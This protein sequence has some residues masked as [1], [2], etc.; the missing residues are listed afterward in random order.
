MSRKPIFWISLTL[1][2]LVGIAFTLR[3]FSEAFPIVTLN[4]KM[5]RATA[6]GSARNLAAR[7]QW[8]PDGFSQAASFELDGTVQNYVE[9]EVGRSKAFRELLREGLYAPYTWRVRHFKEGEAHEALV[10]FTPEGTPYG[11]LEKLR[12][13][14]P[15]SSL[16]PE[17]ARPIAE[18]AAA[19]DW[20]IRLAEYVLIESSQERRPGG[21]TD[22]AFVYERPDRKIGEGL[23]RLRL[24]VGGDK[25]TELTHFIK[26]PEAF[27][28]RYEEMRSAN[29]T[30]AAFAS[31]AM[32]LLYIVGGCAVGLFF[33][34]RQ[35][36]VLWR[37]PLFWG[38]FIAF[39]NLLSDISE[40]PLSW[41]QYDTALSAR[42]FLT[43]QLLAA[44]GGFFLWT[45]LLTLT[46]MAAE[47]L[48]RKAFPHLIRFWKLWSPDTASSPSVLG[49]TL[50][51]YL[52]VGLDFAFVVATYFLTTR[53]FGWWTPSDVLFQPN[54]LATYFPWLSPI[55]QSLQAG[56][57]E[58]CLFRA[59][60]LA[61]AALLGDR[62]GSRKGF[63]AVGFVLQ[64]LI[65][66]A[67]HANYPSQPAYA[68][69]VEL[70]IPSFVFGG[71]YL[72]FGL[73]PAIISHFTFD[74][75]W[76]SIPLF[77][78]TARGVWISQVMVVLLTLTPLWVVLRVRLRT[79]KWLAL[80]DKHYNR[81]WQPEPVAVEIPEKEEVPATSMPVLSAR[82]LLLATAAGLALWML[83]TR[84][85]QDAAPLTIG[86]PE[87]IRIA[88]ETLER[89]GVKLTREWEVLPSVQ[90]GVDQQDRF[91]WQVG[92]EATYRRL[93]G[94]YLNPPGWNVRFARFT[95]D[96][97]ERT[98]E[99]NV[100]I[101]RDGDVIQ[102][103]HQ[104]PESLPGA[105]LAEAEA[106]RVAHAALRTRF[107]LD[108]AQLQE[109]S[110]V[111][112]KLPKRT[113]WVF[114]FSDPRNY[115]LKVGQGRA[116]ITVAGD[117]VA[118]AHQF[119]FV[120][121]EWQRKERSHRNIADLIRIACWS[122]LGLGL[123]AAGVFAIVQWSRRD[124]ST[125]VFVQVVLLVFVFEILNGWNQWPSVQ[126]NFSTS[127]PLS[128]Q[129][130]ITIAG[131]LVGA[132]LQALLFAL[133]MG[134]LARMIPKPANGS[135][136]HSWI[137]AASVAVVL[138]GVM[139]G[140]ASWFG[141]DLS[142]EFADYKPATAYLPW[143]SGILSGTQTWVIATA[144]MLL[145]FGML[146][147]ISHAGNRRRGVTAVL[148][149][150]LGLVL[151]GTE[152]V[153]TVG[154]WFLSGSVFGLLLWLAYRYILRSDLAVVPIAVGITLILNSVVEAA[155]A[156]FPLA[157]VCSLFEVFALV[158]LAYWGRNRLFGQAERS[159]DN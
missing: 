126:A 99:Y 104:L 23:Y 103:S 102:V 137:R 25:L 42:E 12:E 82:W 72:T 13:E 47:S 108:A 116:A 158:V 107:Q 5:D 41:M 16:A 84:F 21:R 55:A 33:L 68:R 89:Q 109:V 79:G 101:V 159:V 43:R 24:V 90:G 138:A 98:E 51:G 114:T 48:T 124:F 3:Y 97:V 65:F 96:V 122:F 30:I 128:H 77:V 38:L 129:L 70:I 64:A 85:E 83:S 95:G 58:E 149:I 100:A 150:V 91:V 45:L 54:V 31:F 52:V 146:E 73:L 133:V 121:E 157:W 111:A 125:S 134:Y 148:C 144:V 123:L 26:V 50:G 40:L 32:L 136:L 151:T 20:Q 94:S 88:R 9:L 132:L 112:S 154:Y 110:A 127:E 2:S 53:R 7:F 62:F 14:A 139:A 35:R 61:G 131:A 113:D 81:T 141:P 117:Q 92:G 8:G 78:S 29:N 143:I 86:R 71:L 57:W 10:R 120:P 147:Q 119:V 135:D 105:N 152:A 28:R 6:L 67:G 59:V 93:M 19:T 145:A 115:P 74:V 69:V 66:G 56:F 1:V 11:F 76:F 34:L 44:L 80:T 153:E 87:A 37:K 156:A 142:P 27:E 140:F 17:A 15:G 60:P 4:L 118:D 39:L 63:L 130:M 36:R 22:H 106:R 18:H 49:H 46:F 75:V 155:S